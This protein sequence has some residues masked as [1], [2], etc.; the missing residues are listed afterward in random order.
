MQEESKSKRIPKKIKKEVKMSPAGGRSDPY[1]KFN[2]L[3]EIDGIA[4]AG[5]LSVE[6]IETLTEVVHYREGNEAAET[7]KL[8]GL[9][10]FTNITLKRGVTANRELW[11]WRKTVLDG[12]TQRKSGSIIVLD[13]SRQ[14][15]MRVNF[16]SAWPCRWKIGEL[17]AME[18][19][20][21]IEELELVVEGLEMG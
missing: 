13:E 12:Q 6:G 11:D 20:V 3:V 5:F 10:K 14:E 21:L 16:L 17:D 19:E 8:P 2:F 15:V 9:H 7:R 18:S 1:R 4:A